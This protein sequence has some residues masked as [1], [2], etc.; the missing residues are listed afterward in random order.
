MKKS[1]YHIEQETLDIISK[2]EEGEVTP[3]LEEALTINKQELQNKAVNYAY[4]IK[5]CD[6]NVS[7]IDEEIKRLQSIKKSE[8]KKSALLKERITSAMNLYGIEEV[9]T[10]TLKL[11]FRSSKTVEIINTSQLESKYFTVK[12][13]R[14]PDKK[15][16][17][18]SLEAGE[19]VPGA[20]LQSNK[21]LQIK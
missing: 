8:E 21:N 1:L 18:Q 4:V 14:T 9:K 2:L 6:F 16:I 7:A 5:E 3:E 12:T 13:T 19:D 10:P 17:K 15:A 20:I 11:N